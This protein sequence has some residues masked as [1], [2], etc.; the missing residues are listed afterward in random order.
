MDYLKHF[1]AGSPSTFD[2]KTD[3]DM[4]MRLDETMFPNIEYSDVYQ[5]PFPQQ[6]DASM[7]NYICSGNIDILS[8]A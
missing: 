5:Q 4:N 7:Y 3:M 1:G 2:T 6:N 8:K